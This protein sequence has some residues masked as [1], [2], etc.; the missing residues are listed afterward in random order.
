MREAA[1]NAIPKGVSSSLPSI[2]ELRAV[3]QPPSLVARRSAEHWAGRL[4]MRRLSLHVTRRVLHLPV[5]ANR[6]TG[7]MIIVGVAGA[8]ILAVPGVATAITAALAVQAYLLLDC[9]DG[10]IARWRRT[11]SATGVYLDRLGHYTVEAALLIAL[12]MR[13][14]G[15]PGS[16]AAATT[17][18]LVAAVLALLS[19]AETDLVTVARVTD[20]LPVDDEPDATSQ[21]ATLRDV[22]RLFAAVPIHRMLGAVELSLLAVAAAVVDAVTASTVGSR[23]LLISAVAVGAVVAVGHPLMILTSRRLQP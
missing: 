11:T 12:G 21:V 23:V 7:V 13:V 2:A 14:D 8:A 16:F 15:G 3:C 22:R 1:R 9:V 17:L 10:E 20:G 4:Y 19:K 18:G 6:W 5:T